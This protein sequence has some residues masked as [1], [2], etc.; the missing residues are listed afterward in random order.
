MAFKT[1]QDGTVERYQYQRY[2]LV[3]HRGAWPNIESR[4]ANSA[5]DEAEAL[6]AGWSTA[7]PA[8]PEPEPEKPVLTLEE[9]V[10]ALE[11]LIL[12]GT[13]CSSI[14]EAAASVGKKRGPGRP[15]K[16][17]TDAS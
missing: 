3:L 10:A 17:F 14:S 15:R 13:G 11:E 16:E 4:Q 5:E 8:I 9:R 7:R 6:A 1:A 12:A 2:P